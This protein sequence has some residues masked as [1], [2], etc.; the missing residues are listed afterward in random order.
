MSVT[1][2][3]SSGVASTQAFTYGDGAHPD[4]LTRVG[5]TDITYDSTGRPTAYGVRTMYWSRGR[6]DTVFIGTPTTGTNK[7]IYSYNAKGQRVGMTHSYLPPK[8][9]SS[10]GAIAVDVLQSSSKQYYYDNFGRL[11]AER[12]TENYKN[13]GTVNTEITYLYDESS[14]V[15][16][17]YSANGVTYN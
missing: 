14:M 6:L 1:T 13:R 4:R 9:Q 16:F 5:T 11:V 17:M 12:K 15:G 3:N 8:G 2:T 7:Y 10:S